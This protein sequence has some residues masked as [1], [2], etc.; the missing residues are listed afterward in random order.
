MNEKIVDDYT[1][2]FKSSDAEL[3]ENLKIHI[4]KLKELDHLIPYST[5]FFCVTNTLSQ[6]FEYVSKNFS[7]CLSLDIEQMCKEGMTFWWS[8]MHPEEM[9][10][11]LK[12]LQELMLFTLSEIPREDRKRMTYTWNYRIKDGRGSYKN[13]IQHTT[14]MYLD[15]E[16]KPVIG[17]AHYSVISTAEQIPIQATAKILNAENEYETLFYQSYNVQSQKLLAPHISHREIDI[18]RLLSF[19]YNSEEI[20]ERLSISHNTVKTHRKNI[21]D[22][23][24]CKNTTE[25]VALCIRQGII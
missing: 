7:S 10:T 13:I 25:L 19:G 15:D 14:P 2:I 12:S 16:G 23:S 4:E 21:L 3:D 1:D 22:K 20:A 11:W 18:L 9:D 5:T 6:S 8:R 24:A 17:L